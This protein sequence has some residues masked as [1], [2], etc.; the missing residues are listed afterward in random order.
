MTST[1][2]E[3][4]SV[5]KKIR[6]QEDI[7]VFFGAILDDR[8]R[9][10]KIGY[11]TPHSPAE[12]CGLL[13]GDL[14]EEIDGCAVV[15]HLDL[16]TQISERQ[17]GEQITV[18]YQRGPRKH[19]TKA[20]LVRYD[21]ENYTGTGRRRP[22]PSSDFAAESLRR[23]STFTNFL[24]HDI[25]YWADKADIRFD[26]ALRQLVRAGIEHLKEKGNW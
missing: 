26:E 16:L 9:R 15:T 23:S 1:I 22:I 19:T 5:A 4:R 11:L 3:E 20:T 8:A 24:H 13:I 14:I 25:Q 7:A 10:G 18:K 21:P 12:E 2:Q 6:K 17:P